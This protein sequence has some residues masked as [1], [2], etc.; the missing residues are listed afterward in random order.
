MPT[1]RF[2][3]PQL[4]WWKDAEFNSF[5]DRFGERTGQ[6][7]DRRWM[8]YQLAVMSNIVAGDTAECGVYRGA[9]S[10]LICKATQSNGTSRTHFMF[11]SFQGVSKPS[12]LYDNGYWREGDLCCSLNDFERPDGDISIHPGW[13]PDRFQDAADR[14]FSFVHVD[15]DLYEPTAESIRF[16]Y[17]RMNPG[18]IMVFD[19]YGFTTCP[20]AKKAVDD[21]MAGK[22]ERII[23]LSCGSAFLAK[24]Y[25]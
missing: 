21:F 7:T 17:S 8:L 14:H 2:C 13:I 20:G 16:F 24:Q 23:Q 12:N 25:Y 18:G 11:D 4:L 5:L 15:V 6:E 22:P 3:W 9:G 10:H 1:Y 19:D